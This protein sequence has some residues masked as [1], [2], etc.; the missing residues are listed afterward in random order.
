MAK[1]RARDDVAIQVVRWT[2]QAEHDL[3]VARKNYSIEVYDLAIV[4]CEQAVEKALKGLY[5]AQTRKPPPRTHS[6]KF[7]AA[8]TKLRP[9]LDDTLLRLEEFY[10]LLRYPEPDGPLPYAIATEGD[11]GEIIRLT[12]LGL[13]LIFEE[14]QRVEKER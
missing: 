9:K 12:A 4:M 2:A 7:F 6:I 10:V 13:E 5:L 1:R 11:A 3:E 8:E 14:I